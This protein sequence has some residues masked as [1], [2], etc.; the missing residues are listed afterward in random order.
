VYSFGNWDINIL[1]RLNMLY[2]KNHKASSKLWQANFTLTILQHSE[3]Q[4][5]WTPVCTLCRV[6]N[7]TKSCTCSNQLVPV[8][9]GT[10]L[11]SPYKE[12]RRPGVLEVKTIV[13][14]KRFVKLGRKFSHNAELKWVHSKSVTSLGTR[15]FPKISRKI[16]FTKCII[17]E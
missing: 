8:S 16:K 13:K 2:K 5:K 6:S 15:G 14:N 7:C 11:Q 3:L 12:L 4:R 17:I 1:N 10:L 9:A